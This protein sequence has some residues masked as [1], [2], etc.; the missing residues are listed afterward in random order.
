M[1]APPWSRSRASPAPTHS[2]GGPFPLP[3]LALPLARWTAV[4]PIGGGV[5][6]EWNLDDTRAGTPGRLALYAG[7]AAP[8]PHELPEPVS[9]REA[10]VRGC[11]ARLRS[12]PLEEAQLSLRPVRELEWERGGLFLRL[13]AQGPWELDAAVRARGFDR[14]VER[15]RRA[16]ARVRP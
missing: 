1:I 9:E 10:A 6:V 2:S 5:E 14:S 8:P 3:A 12:A 16:I 13:T 15:P 4:A 11:P 7:A